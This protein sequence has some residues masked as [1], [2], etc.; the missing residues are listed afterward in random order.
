MNFRFLQFLIPN[1]TFP[2]SRQTAKVDHN[3]HRLS[4]LELFCNRQTRLEDEFTSNRKSL[5]FLSCGDS[6]LMRRITLCCLSLALFFIHGSL[7]LPSI[8]RGGDKLPP[9]C[10]R[11]FCEAD[12]APLDTKLFSSVRHSYSSGSATGKRPTTLQTAYAPAT[13]RTWNFNYRPATQPKPETF[14]VM[15]LKRHGHICFRFHPFN[16]ELSKPWIAKPEPSA[17]KPWA[18]HSWAETQF[19]PML[20][21]ETGIHAD[22]T[23]LMRLVADEAAATLT[24]CVSPLEIL[25]TRAIGLASKLIFIR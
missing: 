2:F 22:L 20:L 21:W 8:A 13:T 14:S 3:P 6:Q 16:T 23:I 24:T 12:F 25:P 19:A 5:P 11:Y 7:L 17:A 4:N 18:A 1:S 10:C 15:A 9:N